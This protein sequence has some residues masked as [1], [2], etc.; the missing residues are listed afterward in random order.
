MFWLIDSGSTQHIT[1]DRS[2]FTS[3]MKLGHPEM[4]EGIGGEPVAAVGI[5]IIE[6]HCKTPAGVSIVTLQEVRH[7][8]KARANM[9]ALRRATYAGARVTI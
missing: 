6:L 4:I 1:R 8:S 3:Y 9:F 7:V 2:K 5:G